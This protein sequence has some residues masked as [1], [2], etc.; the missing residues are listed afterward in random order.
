MREIARAVVECGGQKP[1]A[2]QSDAIAAASGDLGQEGVAAELSNK[3][4]YP[5]A[6]TA[7]LGWV[8]GWRIPELVL[9]VSVTEAV[10]QVAAG[11]HGLEEVRVCARDG[12]E[13]GDSLTELDAM[14]AERVQL[15]DG[16]AG[17]LDL[18]QGIEVAAVGGL[19]DLNVTP[20]IV[21]AFV[22]AHP[23]AVA[24]ATAI[25]LETKDPEVGRGVDHGLDPQ[26]APL[27]VELEPVLANAVFDTAPLGTS[28]MTGLQVSGLG[29][30]LETQEAHHVVC[31]ECT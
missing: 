30:T 20:E 22:H 25:V 8:R 21:E 18:S 3:A 11:E 17:G 19:A 15:C 12:A 4:A 28:G 13:T 16:G 27:V 24:T 7:A 5:L 9:E 2:A 10:D 29:S 26:D 1:A 31:G 14:T 6:S 23:A